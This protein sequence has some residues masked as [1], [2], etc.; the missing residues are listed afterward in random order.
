MINDI[1]LRDI[2]I[3]CPV[4]YKLSTGAVVSLMETVHRVIGVGEECDDMESVGEVEPVHEEAYVWG[5][6]G[7]DVHRLRVTLSR[8]FSAWLSATI[9]R[10]MRHTNTHHRELSLRRPIL[11][12]MPLRPLRQLAPPCNAI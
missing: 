5:M 9:Q 2:M 3:S 12:L 4:C 1:H 7:I 6:G 10:S 8:R 11:G